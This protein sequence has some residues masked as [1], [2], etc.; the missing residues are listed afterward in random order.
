MSSNMTSN[1][2]PGAA[3]DVVALYAPAPANYTTQVSPG[4]VYMPGNRMLHERERMPT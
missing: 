1:A 4:P 3:T 2:G